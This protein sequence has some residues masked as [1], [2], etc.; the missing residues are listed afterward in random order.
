MKHSIIDISDYKKKFRSKLLKSKQTSPEFARVIN[1]LTK[2]NT[3][4]VVGGYLRDILFEKQSRDIDIIIQATSSE[5]EHLVIELKEQQCSKNRLG[6]YKLILENITIDF[7]SIDNNWA[8]KNNLVK[9]S[10]KN[11]LNSLAKGC[12]YNFDS[13][14]INMQTLELNVR[15]FNECVINRELDILMSRPKYRNLNPTKEANILRAIYLRKVYE[16]EFSEKLFEYLK[17]LIL[18]IPYKEEKLYDRLMFTVAKYDKY[19]S[20]ISQEDIALFL[21]EIKHNKIAFSSNWQKK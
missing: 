11:I 4:Y 3:A 1:A 14:V 20:V 15:Y 18:S 10:D 7:W 21:K 2:R 19:Q 5:L 12:F 16:F 9:Y 17:R 8:F 6:G 13:L